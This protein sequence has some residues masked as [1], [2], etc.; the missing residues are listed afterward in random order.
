MGTTSQDNQ[1]HARTPPRLLFK[2]LNPLMR[3][4]L[5]SPLHRLLSARLLLLTV[6]GR[7]TGKCYTIP[8]G[9]AQVGRTLYSGTEG[10]WATNLCGGAPVTV[11]LKGDRL[12][13]SGAVIDDVDGMAAAY[14]A[15]YA[16]SPGYA[17]ALARSAGIS[18]RPGGEVPRDLVVRAQSASHVVIRTTLLEP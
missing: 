7:R 14:R 10:R 6:S 15:I 16:A 8:L 4:L 3:A 17:R 2:L 18:F 11:T 13:A 1:P 12:S 9:Y 5:R